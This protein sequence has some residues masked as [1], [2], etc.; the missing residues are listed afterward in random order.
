M[1][2]HNLPPTPYPV[3]FLLNSFVP[4]FLPYLFYLASLTPW[5]LLS[6]L[7]ISYLLFPL[8]SDSHMAH[9]ITFLSFYS[10]VVLSVSLFLSILLKIQT[11]S[12]SH[13]ST[14]YLS[15]LFFHYCY[16]YLNS[17]YFNLSFPSSPHI[18][19]LNILVF[20][21]WKVTFMMPRT[22]IFI[23]VFTVS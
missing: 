6:I 8:T 15:S 3:P 18:K 9:T 16:Q 12:L 14:P 7:R 23:V 21:H 2:P 19:I 5:C 10:S 22:F 1:S 13:P 20:P 17:I 11:S 4:S